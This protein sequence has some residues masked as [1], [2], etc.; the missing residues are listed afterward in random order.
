LHWSDKGLVG[1]PGARLASLVSELIDK[2]IS[3]AVVTTSIMSSSMPGY[4]GVVLHPSLKH[5]KYGFSG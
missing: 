3:V 5:I 1:L 4:D 2:G